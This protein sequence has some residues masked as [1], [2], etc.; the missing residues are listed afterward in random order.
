MIIAQSAYQI[1]ITLALHFMGP[2]ALRP[3]TKSGQEASAVEF[4]W[5]NRPV[6]A[7]S[8]IKLSADLATLPL[9]ADTAHSS[10]T[11]SYGARSST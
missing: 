10:S 3:I 11:F 7:V 8:L 4:G 6:L 2:K 1:A 9:H 5:V